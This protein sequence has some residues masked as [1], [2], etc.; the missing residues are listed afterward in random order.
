MRKQKNG[1]A[2]ILDIVMGS[3]DIKRLSVSLKTVRLVAELSQKIEYSAHRIYVTAIQ[4][5]GNS[6]KAVL[7]YV[8]ELY[9]I[10]AD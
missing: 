5:Y 3:G 8:D 9:N 2:R 10:T 7:R 4:N 1:D 6:E